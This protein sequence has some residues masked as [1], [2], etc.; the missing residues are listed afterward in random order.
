[1][2]ATHRCRSVHLLTGT[3]GTCRAESK[4]FGSEQSVRREES[5]RCRRRTCAEVATRLINSASE[6][7]GADGESPRRCFS[8][9]SRGHHRRAVGTHVSPSKVSDPNQG[10]TP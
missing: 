2:I 8:A 6:D 1:T 10:L 5:R 9:L 7:S 3:P 4:S